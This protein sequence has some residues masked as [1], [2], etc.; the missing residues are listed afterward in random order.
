MI[1]ALGVTPPRDFDELYAAGAK[2][3]FP[4]GTVI[5][6]AAVK[7]LED[8]SAE[9]FNRPQLRLLL[10]T[11]STAHNQSWASADH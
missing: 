6:D 10:P 9:A 5:A 4:P 8:L 7:L 11:V 1:V 2:A 3:I